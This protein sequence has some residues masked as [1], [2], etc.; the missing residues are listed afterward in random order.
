MKTISTLFIISILFVHVSTHTLQ[1]GQSIATGGSLKSDDDIF[2]LLVQTDGN[3]VVYG[4]KGIVATWATG[5]NNSTA[6]RNLLMQTDGNL[7]LY[8]NGVAK[9][10]SNTKGK[11]SG[12]YT[13]NMQN[14]G[15]LVIYASGGATWA[16]NTM[17][18][19]YCQLCAYIHDSKNGGTG[20]QL[21]LAY[22]D[23][24]SNY[25][26]ECY[27]N[28]T[29][30]RANTYCC[31]PTTA[32]ID[33]TTS[34]DT[35]SGGKR[36]MKIQNMGADEAAIGGMNAW[37]RDINYFYSADNDLSGGGEIITWNQ[38]ALGYAY[39][40]ISTG[41]YDHPIVVTDIDHSYSRNGHACYWTYSYDK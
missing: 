5:T 18:Q 13:L 8:E 29:K 20:S 3:V 9:W 4:C 22:Y 11:G 33:R 31:S 7:V 24:N 21:K 2:T 34:F 26:S 40:F 37:G 35:Y 19:G 15:N 32:T 25:Y 10:A 6:Q 39:F 38:D 41:D 17:G 14:D 12:P 30:S 1:G 23:F 16:S 36:Y 27:L 28:G